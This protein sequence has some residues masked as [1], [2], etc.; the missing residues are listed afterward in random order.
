M[1]RIKSRR[2][3]LPPARRG[4]ILDNWAAIIAQPGFVCQDFATIPTITAY[5]ATVSIDAYAATTSVDAYSATLTI[6][7]YGGTAT[8][9]GR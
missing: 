7:A 3:G 1:G 8:N 2:P 6:D 5:S 4:N 9:C